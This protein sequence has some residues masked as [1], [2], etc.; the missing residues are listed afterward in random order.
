MNNSPENTV[1]CCT[2]KLTRSNVVVDRDYTVFDH[3]IMKVLLVS[4]TFSVNAA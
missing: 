1:I 2:I 3:V 4:G